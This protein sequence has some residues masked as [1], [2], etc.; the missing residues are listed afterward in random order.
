M[1]TLPSSRM[2]VA[3]AI[4]VASL[5]VPACAAAEPEAPSVEPAHHCLWRVDGGVSPVYLLGSVHALRQ[6]DYP[7]PDAIQEAFERSRVMAFE[8]DFDTMTA[9]AMSML[10]K[11]TLDGDQ[12]LQSVLPPE[13]WRRT[14]ERLE[15]SGLPA[16]GFSKMRPW[17]VAL[18]LTSFELIRVGYDPAF[19][20]DQHFWTL[21]GDRGLRRIGLET[22]DDQIDLFA[23]LGAEESAEFLAY[24]LDELDTLAG[25]MDDLAADWRQG[26][27]VQIEALMAEGRRDYPE[28]MERIADD[29]NR[30]WL[31][32]V[33]ELTEGKEPAMVVVGALHLIGDNGLVA[34]L[35]K[36]GYTVTQL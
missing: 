12:T 34:L 8:V 10:A 14:K 33:V 22:V 20:V 15:A 35:R 24:T 21:A 32:K 26:R 13:V 7:L 17:M 2:P 30:T 28:L 6:D 18:S 9:G 4:L 3:V 5:V 16:A 11:G 29:R 27:L 23:S 25:M 1:I 19:G 36:K 31:P